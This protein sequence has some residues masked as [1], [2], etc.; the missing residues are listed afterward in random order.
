MT[1]K[2]AVSGQFSPPQRDVSCEKAS[3]LAGRRQIGTSGR[4]KLSGQDDLNR[5]SVLVEYI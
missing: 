5:V 2:P 4:D 3:V 1:N